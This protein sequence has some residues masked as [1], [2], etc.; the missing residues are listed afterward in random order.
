MRGL[1]VIG[2]TLLLV[3][4][5]DVLLKVVEDDL[6]KSDDRLTITEI[7][8][9]DEESD[10]EIDIEVIIDDVIEADETA[11]VRLSIRCDGRSVSLTPTRRRA[12]NSKVVW[13]EVE[14]EDYR[15]PEGDDVLCIV[16][17]RAEIDHEDRETTTEFKIRGTIITAK[18][19]GSRLTFTNAEDD[20]FVT[21]VREDNGSSACRA[22]LVVWPA[23]DD[24][25]SFI[26]D[27][28][29]RGVAGARIVR[30]K[31]EGLHLTGDARRCQLQVG[32][33]KVDIPDG[34]EYDSDVIS[35]VDIYDTNRMRIYHSSGSS[36]T[37]DVVVYE[38]AGK[39]VSTTRT[40]GSNSRQSYLS[41]SNAY[42]E[43]N[44][45]YTVWVRYYNRV[46]KFT[47]VDGN[48]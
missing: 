27:G 6:P 31:V 4:C 1:W 42:F 8:D 9:I 10:T 36:R 15:D 7:D 38:G 12:K 30:G 29:G 40:L 19:T 33:T 45:D 14:F 34:Y 39:K 11:E 41:I 5:P 2:I 26:I 18:I 46:V 43:R 44:V 16:T 23:N 28:E 22:S 21:I 13:E 25:P 24:E 48:W 47:G 20:Q 35:A 37:V 32:K 17:A 3:G